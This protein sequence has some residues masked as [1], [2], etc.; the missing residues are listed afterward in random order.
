M[1]WYSVEFLLPQRF[2]QNPV[3][4][5]FSLDS[6]SKIM[7]MFMFKIMSKIMHI[8]TMTMVIGHILSTDD[9]VLQCSPMK[10][11]A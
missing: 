8:P 7:F 1:D 3:I 5:T 4:A 6:W 9:D 2:C 11:E 10:V